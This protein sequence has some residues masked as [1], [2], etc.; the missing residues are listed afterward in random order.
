MKNKVE[1]VRDGFLGDLPEE[2]RIKVMNI[3]KVIVDKT[4]AEFKLPKYDTINKTTWAKGWLEEFLAEPSDKNHIGSVRVYKK[5]KRVRCMIQISGHV[6]NNRNT[7]DEELFHGMIRNVFVAIRS[8]VRRKFDCT[9]T[10]ESEHGEPFEGFDI[11][12]KQKT[13]QVVWD[14]FEGLKTKKIVPMK[15]S[16]EE[17]NRDVIY[18]SIFALPNGLQN[19]ILE[20]VENIL[21]ESNVLDVNALNIGDAEIVC[22]NGQYEGSIEIPQPFKEDVSD[23][24]IDN[25]LAS[26]YEKVCDKFEKENPG[27]YLMM[28]QA[29]RDSFFEIVMDPLYAEKLYEYMEDHIDESKEFYV[30]VDA[31]DHNEKFRCVSNEDDTVSVYY[32]DKLIDGG[33]KA[34]KARIEMQSYVNDH[35][36]DFKESAEYNVS[37]SEK[38]AKR[39]LGTLTQQIINDKDHKVTQYTVN[40]YAN[41]IT[42]NLLPIWA[43]GFR[44]LSIDLTSEKAANT[45]EFK[46]P[47]IGKDF[48][49]RYIEGRETIDG[50][51]HRNPEIKIKMSPKMFSTLKN[52]DDGYNFFKATIKYYDQGIAKYSDKLSRT[53]HSLNRDLKYLIS[54][55]KLS[56]LVTCPIQMLVTFDDLDMSSTDG[57]KFSKEDIDTINQFIKNIYT[58]YAAPE[59]EK[60]AIVNDLQEI[61]SSFNEAFDDCQFI[62]LASGVKTYFEGGFDNSI[63]AYNEIFYAEQVDTKWMT[64]NTNPDIKYYQEKFGV[65]KLKKIPRDL[66]AYITIETEAIKD[67]NDKMMIASYC[68]SKIEIV[69][70]YIELLEVGSKKYVVPHTKPYLES[71]RTQL[72]AC[73]KKIMDTP[74]PK[75]NRPII[76]IQYPDGYKG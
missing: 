38:E 59:K 43:H 33:I 6:T 31:G 45:F 51:L 29:G 57:L 20:C 41:I 17:G 40:I 68:T 7:E 56:N 5:G 18:T 26:V 36:D 71:L 32:G 28:E 69:E 62:G 2:L 75:A 44:K 65:K 21:K 47:T 73:Y 27:K 3:H 23:D 54:T 48:I 14:K 67:A 58:R 4:R 34:D 72:L 10:C 22:D 50:L 64:E 19:T 30:T 42:K 37:M 24:N 46:L 66:V 52:R 1:E 8:T 74:I 76:D 61:I 35:I 25:V 16:F 39:T 11:W 15:E 63:N 9:I 13:A 70:W 12:T 53:L 60:T 55:T 49:S